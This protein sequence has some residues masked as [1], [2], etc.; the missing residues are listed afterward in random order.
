MA[1]PATVRQ[2]AIL[3]GGLATRLGAIS[4]GTPKPAL[5]IGGRP[6]LAWQMQEISRFGVDEILFLCGHL[7][8][9]LREIVET[10]AADLPRKLAIRFSEEPFRAGTGGALF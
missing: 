5:P 8:D 2:C 10:I 4:A 3:A 7:S 9:R 1:Q 6:F